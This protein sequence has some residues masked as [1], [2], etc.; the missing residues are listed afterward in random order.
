MRRLA[1][2]L[3]SHRFL[4][5]AQWEA[6]FLIVRLVNFLTGQ[7]R[8]LRQFL[9]THGSPVYLNFGSGPRGKDSVHWLNIDGY[10]DHNVHFQLDFSRSLPLADNL[11]DGAFCEHV[12][13][14]FSY[15]DGQRVC[16]EINRVLRPGGVF[17]VIVPDAELIVR[18]YLE[19]PE[20]LVAY[21]GPPGATAM[22]AV[23]SLFR[24]RYEHQFLYDWQ[25]MERMLAS[26]GF[27]EVTRRKPGEGSCPALL[28]DDDK[29][30][31]ESLYV[32]AVKAG[33]GGP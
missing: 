31:W 23:N 8:R 24:Q 22:Q 1:L 14:H 19:D 10:H 27:A 6:H 25:T 30:V 17:R 32:E 16:A 13:E 9:A 26:A 28:I 33:M 3:F 20:R 11:F 5:L 29:Y 21:R 15:E 12:I 2:F 4:A 7:N 18:T